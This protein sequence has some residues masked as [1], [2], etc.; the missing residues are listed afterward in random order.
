M[1]AQ[2]FLRFRVAVAEGGRRN[3]SHGQTPSET[4]IEKGVAGF[5]ALL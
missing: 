1:S 4:R 5:I 2:A 3:F